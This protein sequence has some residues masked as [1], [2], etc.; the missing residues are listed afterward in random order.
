[1]KIIGKFYHAK[2][3]NACRYEGVNDSG[4]ERVC[5][6]KKCEKVS[7]GSCPSDGLK[8]PIKKS[9]FSQEDILP[10]IPFERGRD[11]DFCIES[12]EFTEEK[13]RHPNLKEC[14]IR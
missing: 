3:I 8:V 4:G 7:K 2:F 6:K 5:Q 12:P 9:S 13:M 1:L 11:T 10:Q 14:R